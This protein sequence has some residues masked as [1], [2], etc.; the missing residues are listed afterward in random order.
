[1]T[2]LSLPLEGGSFRWSGGRNWTGD[3]F[4]KLERMAG[5]GLSASQ[6]GAAFGATRNSIIGACRR[7]GIK[8]TGHSGVRMGKPCVILP[9]TEEEVATL[10]DRLARGLAHSEIAHSLPG[11][12]PDAVGRKAKALG[13]TRT[14]VKRKD[15]LEGGGLK[16]NYVLRW[17]KPNE[18][19]DSLN[20]RIPVGVRRS[21]MELTE[22]ACRW[23]V[24]D[25]G[26]E[27]FFFCG[28][29]AVKGRPYCADHCAHAYQ[30]PA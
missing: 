10:R 12:T 2:E 3:D 7:A 15:R 29:E 8:L 22:R 28:T 14:K 23:P 30:V 5:E 26:E 9:W 11:R 19:L 4:S 13:L 21:F 18:A 20:A 6:I 24:G 16:A 1:M 27:G 17:A 25:V